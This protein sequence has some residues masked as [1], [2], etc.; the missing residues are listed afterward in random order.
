MQIIRLA[1][2]QHA[3]DEVDCISIE[4]RSDGRYDLQGAALIN[5]GDSDESESVALVGLPPFTTREEAEDVGLAWAAD[6]CVEQ[7][8]IADTGFN[9]PADQ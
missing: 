6:Q 5:C 9:V 2:G 3:S 4:H 1:S 8:Y 7:L